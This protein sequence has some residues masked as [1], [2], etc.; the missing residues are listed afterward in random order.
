MF[1]QD[2][3]AVRLDTPDSDVEI[4]L[5]CF[6][7][8]A[9]SLLDLLEPDLGPQTEVFLK[10]ARYRYQTVSVQSAAECLELLFHAEH[11]RAVGTTSCNSRSSR[12][13]CV[14][15]FDVLNRPHG[16]DTVMKGTLSFVDLAGSER[17]TATCKVSSKRT[18]ELNVSLASLVR[19][20]RQLQQGEL[21]ETER[22]QSVLNKMIFDYVQ[23]TCGI[24]LLFCV[25]QE[26]EYRDYTFSTLQLA[27]DSRNIRLTQQKQTFMKVDTGLIPLS[28][29]GQLCVEDDALR[30]K[31]NL[32]KHGNF[33]TPNSFETP[34]S[35]LAE[36]VLCESLLSELDNRGEGSTAVPSDDVST[37]DYAQALYRLE[38]KYKELK[39]SRSAAFDKVE[40]EN[41]ELRNALNAERARANSLEG[42]IRS[43]QN[44]V[45]DTLEEINKFRGA[46][47]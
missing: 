17:T 47:R 18:R 23:P 9:E 29:R 7:I 4:R 19:L 28:A 40:E 34:D 31:F 11:E 37:E 1:V 16:S 32:D 30:E 43:E 10:T 44:F 6:E 39:Y 36:N 20:F 5:R 12:S 46:W 42:L 15:Q 21:K 3:F 41:K 8:Y 2:L 27:S 35:R 25:A 33:V 13:H 38:R 22:R 24:W 26:E 14:V 45:L